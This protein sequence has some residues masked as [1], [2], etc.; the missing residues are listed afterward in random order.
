M[1]AAAFTCTCMSAYTGDTCSTCAPGFSAVA[2]EGTKDVECGE[3]AIAGR[4]GLWR[5]A[6]SCRWQPALPPSETE[7]ACTSTA[8]L[9]SIPRTLLHVIPLVP[10]LRRLAGE[11]GVLIIS[12]VCHLWTGPRERTPGSCF[13]ANRG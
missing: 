3:Q 11:L 7:T 1:D 10:P 6:W 9:T 5:A 8:A 2:G 13:A 12:R 4:V